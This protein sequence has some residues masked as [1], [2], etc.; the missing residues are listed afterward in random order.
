MSPLSNIETLSPSR[1]PKKGISRGQAGKFA[2][3]FEHALL[4]TDIFADMTTEDVDLFVKFFG[5]SLTSKFIYLTERRLWVKTHGCNV[6][7]DYRHPRAMQSAINTND[8]SQIYGGEEVLTSI[9]VPTHFGQRIETVYDLCLNEPMHHYQLHSALK[10]WGKQ[11]GFEHGY[12]FVHPLVALLWARQN[13]REQDAYRQLAT[14]YYLEGKYYC[15]L[16]SGHAEDRRTM[17]FFEEQG[18]GHWDPSTRFL[19]TPSKGVGSDHL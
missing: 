4:K 8:F 15:L 17:D 3:M 7:V 5:P 1:K 9:N 12:K 11:D 18:H 13:P 16:L 6:D 14:Y 19:V 2:E 10:F